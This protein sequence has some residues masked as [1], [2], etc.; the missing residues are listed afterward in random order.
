MKKSIIKS[1][2]FV[3]I[4][5]IACVMLASCGNP[6]GK[7]V[8]D[9]Y[10]LEFDGENVTV[11]WKGITGGT[12]DM[13]GTYVIEKDDDGNK[14]ISFDWEESDNTMEEVARSVVKAIFSEDLEYKE[15]KDDDG[16]YIKIADITFYKEK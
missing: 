4:I 9:N 15:G 3:L 10:T 14:T 8:S 11:S 6:S 12:Y 16:N 7:Q 2:A 1:T 13:D 5:T